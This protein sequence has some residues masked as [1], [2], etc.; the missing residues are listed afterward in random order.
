[1]ASSQPLERTSSSLGGF[2][3][4]TVC[5]VEENEVPDWEQGIALE[6]KPS[7][8]LLIGDEGSVRTLDA[9]V[10]FKSIVCRKFSKLTVINY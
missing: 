8:D 6:C 3:L 2:F 1:M 10:V 4:G 9:F 5:T 7:L